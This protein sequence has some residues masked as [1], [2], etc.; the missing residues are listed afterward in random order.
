MSQR[1]T[2][3]RR[4]IAGAVS[5]SIAGS[6]SAAG[7]LEEIVVTAQKREEILQEVPISITAFTGED[8]TSRSSFDVR[9]LEQFTPGLTNSSGGTGGA[10]GQGNYFIRGVGQSEF[11]AVQDPG[12]ATYV[13]GVYYGRTGGANFRLLDIERIEVLRGPQGTLFGRNA[14]GGAIHV[15]TADPTDEFGG[16]ALVR[17]GSRDRLDGEALVNLP[18]SDTLS[19]KVSALWHNQDGP[20]ESVIDD[21]TFGDID[22]LGGRVKLLF[23]PSDSFNALLNLDATRNEGTSTGAILL[24]ANENNGRI[25]YGLQQV[26]FP[27]EAT[28]AALRARGIDAPARSGISSEI[29]R[30]PYLSYQSAEPI[31]DTETWGAALTLNFDF[32]AFGVRSISAYRELDQ[33]VAND[34]DGSRFVYFDQM[35]TTVQDQIT[36]EIQV[37]GDGE[38]LDW[39]VGAFYFTETSDQNN[40]IAQGGSPFRLDYNSAV[41]N[42]QAFENETESYAAFSQLTFNVTEQ[43]SVTGGVR[44]TH[45]KKDTDYD[46][47]FDNRAGTAVYVNGGIFPPGVNFAW[48]SLLGDVVPLAPSRTNLPF[49]PGSSCD[50]ALISPVPTPPFGAFRCVAPGVLPINL[51]SIS[52]SWDSWTGR[53]A[54]EY[55]ASDDLLWYLSWSRGFKS[56]GVNSRPIAPADVLPFDPETVDQYETG[57]KADWLDNRLRTNVAAYYSDYKDMQQLYAPPPPPP[58]SNQPQRFFV[59]DNVG[60]VE[61]LGAELELIAAPTDAWLFNLGVTWME[62]EVKTVKVLASGIIEGNELTGRPDL[63]LFAGAQYTFNLGELGDLSLR[64]DYYSQ[65]DAWDDAQNT[66]KAEGYDLINARATYTEPNG[67]WNVSAF[68]RNLNDE[69]YSLGDQNVVSSFGTHFGWYGMPR[70]W[71]LEAS[72][73][74]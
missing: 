25:F 67:R 34:Y 16:K 39:Q 44:F 60:D 61:I 72:I 31:D 10:G 63:T 21:R 23:K 45:E 17:T 30:D 62:T 32:D 56:G 53:A 43:W 71:G 22:T 65:G 2:R 27:N 49:L 59:I 28:M 52:D 69:V 18:I 51:P 40:A 38:R 6:V 46:F 68:G 57:L 74:F 4:L 19:T 7:V 73:N 15:I 58:G 20:T 42:N 8:L 48:P 5:A 33:Q 41:I 54:L 66:N 9:D 3:V 50:G 35:L 37:F 70:E 12:V 55:Q 1:T 29:S 14:V 24:N 26:A 47:N 11:T 64:A 13:D 36:Q